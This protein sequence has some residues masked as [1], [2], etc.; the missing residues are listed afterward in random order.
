MKKPLFSILTALFF[1]SA[2]F[3][4][5]ELTISTETYVPLSD[6]VSLTDGLTWDDPEL[7]FSLPFNFSFYDTLLKDIDF[8]P[9]LGGDVFFPDQNG[10]GGFF[11]PIGADI[12]DRNYDFDS[13]GGDPGGASH[14]VTKVDGNSGNYILKI[15]WV[16][17][18][19]Y[20]EGDDD[21]F[22]DFINFQM[23]L[24]EKDGV[25]EYRYGPSSITKPIECYEGE[26]G[27]NVGFWFKYNE[28]TDE[29][30]AGNDLSGNP[31]SAQMSQS[32]YPY[33]TFLSGSIPS[34]TVYTFSR[35][36]MNVAEKV[37]TEV[38]F[39]VYPNPAKNVLNVKIDDL[40]QLLDLQ[41]FDLS[42]KRVEM[43]LN[44]DKSVNVSGLPTG[45]YLVQVQTDKGM[46][47]RKFTKL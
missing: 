44:K 4:Q 1:G 7:E 10:F 20:G 3:A 24:Y 13:G 34:N 27:P 35:T 8:S 5:Y 47:T 26:T 29:F 16:N 15:E 31:A 6:S 40:S 39:E 22:E 21:I 23:W 41:I 17:V 33:N 25:I 36:D 12:I 14:I 46:A 28:N 18:G 42:G 11:F 45:M 32:D 43:N 30:E 2:G 38:K 9:G 19:F 37:A